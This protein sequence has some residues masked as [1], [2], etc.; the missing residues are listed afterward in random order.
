MSKSISQQEFEERIKKRFPLEKFN[1]ISYKNM[2]SLLKI[3]C[4]NCQ[5][6]LEYPQAKNFLAK[7]KRAGCSGCYGKQAKHFENLK[8]LQQKYKIIT[9]KKV[10]SSMWYTCE[11]K[12][13]GRIATHTLI[14]FLK[15]SCRCEGKGIHWTEEEL[16]E[17]LKNE[18]Q[19]EYVLLSPFKTVNDKSLFKHSCGFTWSTTPAHLLYNKTGCPKCCRKE[20]KNCKLIENQLKQL[21]IDFE[22][23]KF[24]NDSLQRFDFYFEKDG[25]K[26]AIE[27]NGEQHYK[28]NPFFHGHDISVFEKYQERDKRKQ[29]YC[30]QNNIKL[31]IIPYTFTKEEI[32][33]YINKLFSSS[34]TS[35]LNVASGEA[36]WC[37]SN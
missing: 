34:T 35:S 11:C 17:Y 3:Q 24:L 14:S 25:I 8:L 23:E 27:Y 15:N 30:Q 1:I 20:S 9:Q 7:N 18:Y 6:I 29:N 12:K 31:I 19:N 22:R 5:E 13:C 36:K 4:L 16:K 37:S 28:Y 33:N 26:Y 10:S 2:S 32:K 21:S